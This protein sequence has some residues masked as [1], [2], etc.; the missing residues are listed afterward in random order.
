ML[1]GTSAAMAVVA[2]LSCVPSFAQ[3]AP[4]PHLPWHSTL[5]VFAEA[6]LRGDS[7][8]K[9]L[10]PATVKQSA[11]LVPSANFSSVNLNNRISSARLRCGQ[12]D[13]TA[14][15]FDST[16]GLEGAWRGNV[17]QLEC[18]RGQTAA[19]NFHQ[20]NG[21]PGNVPFGDRVGMAWIIVH[22]A[23]RRPIPLFST[24]L[25][26]QWNQQLPTLL[27][28]S[29]EAD[30]DP[31]LTVVDLKNFDLKQKV[32]I[33]GGILCA[34]GSGW[35]KYRVRVEPA[36]DGYGRATFW[37]EPWGADAVG[38]FLCSDA[39]DGKLRDSA[40]DGA[41]KLQAKL[42]EEARN[43]PAFGEARTFYVS[44]QGHGHLF[45]LESD[46]MGRPERGPVVKP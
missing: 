20:V 16:G 18:T 8:Q 28:S 45:Q 39:Y 38:G 11:W 21:Q 40:R 46:S 44:A 37:V 23:K 12:R 15:F 3:T 10:A 2:S 9:K 5:T 17:V 29:A 24:V 6:G 13:T 35:F 4:G 31:E 33:D 14:Y 1:T 42:N 32:K 26:S 19:V 7:Y 22:A 36:Q 27:P 34:S 25:T 43:N 41:A 30:G